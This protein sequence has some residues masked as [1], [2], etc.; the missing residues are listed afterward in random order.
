MESNPIPTQPRKKPIIICNVAETEY[1]VV[2]HV[3]SK[4]MGWKLSFE[5][6][7]EEWDITWCDLGITPEKLSKMKSYQRINH[8]PGMHAIHKKNYLA[9]NL[10][11]M[12][13]LLPDD[14]SFYPKTWV[15][16]GDYPDFK[17]QFNKK[18]IFII[19]PEASSQ[20]RGIFL[21]RRPEDVNSTERYVAQ[22]YLMDPFLIEGL[23]FDLRIYVLVT[24][25][26]PLRIYIHED[27]LTRLATEEYSPPNFQNYK[28]MC[29]HLT[30]YAINKN[31]PNFVY[32]DDPEDDGSGHKRSLKSTYELLR[33]MNYDVDTLQNQIEEIIVKTLCAIQPSLA[34]VYKSCQP[35]DA[36]N[37]M[38]FELLGFDIII[39]S[40]LKPWLLEVNHAPSFA[41]DSPL[42]WKIKKRVLKE[43]MIMVCVRARDRKNYFLNKKIEIQKRAISGKNFK[44]TKE[45]RAEI[46]R[47]AQEKRNKWENNHLGGFKKAYSSDNKE[48]Y[49]KYLKVAGD[50]WA[51]WTGANIDRTK[52]EDPAK[53][54]PAI[55]VK[56]PLA[57]II[58]RPRD[59]AKSNLSRNVNISSQEKEESNIPQVD[60][61]PNLPVEKHSVESIDRNGQ[62]TN[63][64]DNGVS[65]T[66]INREKAYLVSH[67]NDMLKDKL[68]RE[69]YRKEE[70]A[71]HYQPLR[72]P[73]NQFKSV[74]PQVT[75][76]G[77][78]VT[79]KYFDFSPYIRSASTSKQSY[80]PSPPKVF[81]RR[82]ISAKVP[83]QHFRRE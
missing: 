60:W 8:F 71:M 78:F 43:T 55:N 36:G 34:H 32:N 35:E 37:N 28:E 30:N 1:D 7:D 2:K 59:S 74:D 61:N 44:E 48:K 77:S 63:F 68:N 13:K 70:L 75:N 38:C 22:E 49:E 72:L 11:R 24:G 18:K 39:D 81:Y 52:K 4:S 56:K 5:E 76:N 82:K 58:P 80:E 66:N 67:L 23:K 51:D 25:C 41:T 45:E 40:N 73:Q 31:N 57:K 3:A 69:K 33:S 62:I 79:P 6:N 53:Q 21:A 17:S 14:Y 42:D 27:G 64:E 65:W 9:W 12:Q 16:P 26:N 47:L 50:I 46:A 15:L 19:K 10:N 54:N 20:G 83:I 29:M